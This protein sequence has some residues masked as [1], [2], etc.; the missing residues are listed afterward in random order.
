MRLL[1][2]PHATTEWNASERL[3]GWTDTPLSDVGKRQAALVAR[4]LRIERI[5]ACHTSDLG[6]ATQTGE[7][8]VA[9][10][11]LKFAPDTRLREIHFGAWEGLTYAEVC[12]SAGQEILAWERDP[13]EVAPPG[14]ETLAQLAERVAAFLETITMV[15]RLKSR[16]IVVVGHRGSLRVLVCLE[17]GL[18]PTAWWRFRLE[19]ASISELVLYS[20]GAVLNL[21]NDIHH[22]RESTDAG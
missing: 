21:L 16:T 17:L 12:H 20:Q 1:L 7:A 9:E 14:G 15:G 8:I 3:Q 19:P 6:R 2:V 22:L 11:G 13:M 5:D 4:R 10:R 18:P